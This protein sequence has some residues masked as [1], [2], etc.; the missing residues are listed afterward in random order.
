MIKIVCS[1]NSSFFLLY[2]NLIEQRQ[3]AADPQTM[4]IDLGCDRPTPGTNLLGHS[5]FLAV[6]RESVRVRTQPRGSDRIRSTG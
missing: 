4:Q 1:F 6:V 5:A 2:L 3:A